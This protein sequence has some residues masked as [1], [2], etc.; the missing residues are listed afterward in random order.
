MMV[1]AVFASVTMGDGV[2]PVITGFEL[3]FW[4]NEFMAGDKRIMRAKMVERQ[5]IIIVA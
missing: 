2:W 4:E 5:L 1:I 3:F